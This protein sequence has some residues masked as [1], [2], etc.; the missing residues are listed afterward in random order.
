M[1]G[2]GSKFFSED[3]SPAWNDDKN[4]FNI[5]NNEYDLHT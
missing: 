5:I 3:R 2:L 4:N 1:E